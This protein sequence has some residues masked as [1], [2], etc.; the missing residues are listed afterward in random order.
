[1][2]QQRYIFNSSNNMGNTILAGMV[3]IGFFLLFF[4]IARG[5]FQLLSYAAPVM[6]VVTL[7]VRYQVVTEFAKWLWSKV[8]SEPMV[9][10][11]YVLLT[12]VGFPI[13]SAY[14][15]FKA[16]ASRRLDQVREAYE[17]QYER[18]VEYTEYEVIEDHYL[19]INS[20]EDLNKYE[21]LFDQKSE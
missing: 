4:W 6:L 1:M 5:V 20:E 11:L 15:L 9:G 7:I 14:L 18:P 10:I 21:K 8:K 13:V 2:R 12:A 16:L 3:L 17:N 19:D